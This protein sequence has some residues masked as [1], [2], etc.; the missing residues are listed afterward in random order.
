MNARMRKRGNHYEVFLDV[1]EQEAR[2]CPACVKVDSRGRV[3]GKLYFVDDGVVD[4]C[5]T[6]HGATETVKSRRERWIGSFDRQ[7]DALAAKNSAAGDAARGELVDARRMTVAAFLD[8]WTAGLDQKVA[9]KALKPSTARGYR[10]HIKLHIRP[11]LGP[12]QLQTVTTRHVD[13]FY[14]EL[15]QK[16]GRKAESKLSV[17]TRRHVHVTLHAALDDA[18]RQRLIGFNPADDADVPEGKREKID[19]D[20]VWT[21]DE[22]KT[23]LKSVDGDRLGVLWQLMGTT[24]L[25]RAEALGLRWSDVDLDGA[26][27][28]VRET[29]TSVGYQVT[30]GDPK[31][32]AGKRP[33]PLLPATVAALRKWKAQQRRE[34]LQWGAGW[35]DTGHCFTR[36][37]GRPWHPDRISKLFNRAVAKAEVPRMRLHDLRHGFATM[38]I[39]AGTQAKH[40]QKLMGHS[41]IG[42]TLDTYVHPEYED[43]AVA[44]G[45]LDAVLGG[46]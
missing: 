36:E 3:R 38:H 33:M 6:C 24:G 5:P 1:G 44:Q 2:R 13:E 15:A 12:L 41:R 32:E 19:A 14:A 39:A 7:K 4:E 40:L 23:F 9:D 46:S 43:L 45:N 31:S 18:R 11:K 17:T 20:A 26:V 35:T 10:D 30:V 29:R 34:R 21:V 27:L 28:R 37:D 8:S 42:V 22:W 16:P 25:R